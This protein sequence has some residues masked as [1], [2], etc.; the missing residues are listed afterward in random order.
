MK[1]LK[2][3]RYI[4]SILLVV[5]SLFSI[6][7]VVH[8]FMTIGAQSEGGYPLDKYKFLITKV[9]EPYWKIGY[10][11]HADCTPAERQNSKALTQAISASLRTWL[12]PL[13]ELQPER[14]IVDR[15]VYELQADVN[16]NQPE[17]LEG[18]REVDLRVT[19]QCTQGISIALI[20][21][22]FPP[23]VVM[24]R[25]DTEL[26]PLT[27][28]LLTH[29]LGH[30]FG[31]ADTFAREGIMRSQGGFPWTAHKQPASVMAMP[32]G[33]HDDKLTPLTIGEDD[34][35]GIIWL[36]KYFYEGI[37]KDDCFFADYVY[38][39]VKR[40]GSCTPKHPLIFETKYNPPWHAPQLLKHDPTIDINAQDEDGMT[41]LHY[42]IM[43]EKEEVVKALLAHKDINSLLMNKQGQT[44]LDIALAANH[45]AII[46]MFHERPRRKEDV[47]PAVPEPT[48]LASDV[49]GDGVVNIQDL[50]L[51]A[52]NFGAIGEN[53]ADVNADGTVNIQDLVQVAGQFGAA[54][55]APSAWDRDR[56]VAPTRA[57]VQQW[58]TQAQALN[59]TDATSQRGIR[60]LAQFLLTLI[61]KET[62]LLPNYPNPFN[63]ETWIPYQLVAPGDVTIEIHA[64]DGTLVRTLSLGH[65]P[66]GMYQSR[67]R[68]AYW[69][70]RNQT[71]EPVASG[72][73]FYTLTA[74]E[75]TATRK[76][77]IHK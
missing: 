39:K 16:P 71:G 76:M 11:Y 41:A 1:L 51:I 43:Y 18:L 55:A 30:A 54:A 64:I 32:D 44:P 28:S 2:K 73:Y 5:S 35:R 65:Q 49:N 46:K 62:A 56:K 50:V 12:E 45:T 53:A 38:A 21:I 61:P 66:V 7:P 26:T 69:N 37:A 40:I 42:A 17:D 47:N 8:G 63:P 58:L 59:L 22:I 20:G 6:T 3:M 57:E 24:R 48:R 34:K 31:L 13:K 19:F 72:V 75:F 70:G 27:L 77:L 36:Y 15:F 60:F 29:E 14:P 52:S 33:F 67:S 68:A 23:E 10:R 9:H 74:G 25:R 4:F